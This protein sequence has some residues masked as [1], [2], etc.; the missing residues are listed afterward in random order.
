[1]RTSNGQFAKGSQHLL[2]HGKSYSKIYGVWNSMRMRCGN[3]STEAYRDYGARGI[4]VCER[5]LKFENF[6][7]DMGDQPQGMSL[8][9]IDNDK[10]YEPDNCRWASRGIQARNKRGLHLLTVGEETHPLCEW[11]EISGIRLQTIWFRLRLGWSPEKAVTQPIRKSSRW[12]GAE[13]NVRWS[14]PEREAA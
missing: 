1:M 13:H 12:H 9:R 5:W 2:K 7:A 4:T 14:E 11:A 6:Y 8:D 10:G 3:P